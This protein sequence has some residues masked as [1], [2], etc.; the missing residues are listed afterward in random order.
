MAGSRW[1]T[2]DAAF[3][4]RAFTFT[5]ADTTVEL[6]GFTLTRGYTGPAPAP[7]HGGCVLIDS[8]S[9]ALTDIKFVMCTTC[10][11]GGACN[12]NGGAVAVVNSAGLFGP[13]VSLGKKGRN[14]E[15][16]GRGATIKNPTFF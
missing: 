5:A 16:L 14:K 10:D 1:T 7:P 3:S 8:A 2:I 11:A 13:T 4:G 6:R 9:P 15:V 12:G